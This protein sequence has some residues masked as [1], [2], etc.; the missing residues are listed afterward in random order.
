MHWGRLPREAVESPT[1][2]TLPGPESCSTPAALRPD[3]RCLGTV[4]VLRELCHFPTALVKHQ[5]VFKE[6]KLEAQVANYV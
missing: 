6:N 5:Q 1:H 4:F 3:A 2:P